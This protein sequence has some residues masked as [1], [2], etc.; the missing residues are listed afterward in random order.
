[1]ANTKAKPL[2]TFIHTYLY[3]DVCVCVCMGGKTKPKTV[4]KHTQKLARDMTRQE[5]AKEESER[6]GKR[7]RESESMRWGRTSLATT[8]VV[9]SVSMV[10]CGLCCCCCCLCFHSSLSLSGYSPFQVCCVYCVCVKIN[11]VPQKVYAYTHTNARTHIHAH[12]QRG[13][14][15][16]NNHRQNNALK[17][18]QCCTVRRK[19]IKKCKRELKCI[20]LFIVRTK[21]IHWV[22]RCSLF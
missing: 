10:C 9:L 13:Q 8:Q 11:T 16:K 2:H 7:E 1:M 14:I 22:S 18:Q 6:E 12:A 4:T 3:A 21:S 20:Y 19:L 15:L 17:L 5:V